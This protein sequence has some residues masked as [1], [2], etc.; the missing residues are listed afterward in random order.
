MADLSINMFVSTVGLLEVIQD[1]S[2]EKLP[3]YLYMIR[4]ANP[5]TVARLQID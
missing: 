2:F 1:S 4:R 5:G 3:S